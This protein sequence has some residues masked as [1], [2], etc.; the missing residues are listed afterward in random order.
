MSGTAAAGLPLLLADRQDRNG[1]PDMMTVRTRGS[2]GVRH[3]I[4]A[5][6]LFVVLAANAEAEQ[7]AADPMLRQRLAE[8]LAAA[9]GQ[10]DRFDADVWLA[11]MARRLERRVPD[12]HERLEIL[13]SAY[14]E[15]NRAALPPELVL[16]VIEIESRFDRF[17]ISEAGARGLMQVMPFWLKEI[18][19][20]DDDLFQ[21]DTN[22][23]FG[24]T[25]LKY[26][27]DKEKGDL[28]RALARYNG[29]TGKVWY[30]ERVFEALRARWYR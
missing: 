10:A 8:V 20:P 25:I 29:S 24:C 21:V 16:A 17:A 23:R 22:L 2:D 3:T 26:Y 30:P 27:L 1:L 7:T 14:V 6:I 4:G 15:A 11:D 13:K 12:P 19:R 28:K 9:A 18:G 5:L